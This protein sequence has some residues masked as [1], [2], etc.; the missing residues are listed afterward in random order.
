MNMLFFVERF[1]AIY[2]FWSSVVSGNLEDQKAIDKRDKGS[3]GD[4]TESN[5]SNLTS[6]CSD[7]AEARIRICDGTAGD[8]CQIKICGDL[9]PVSSTPTPV[10]SLN[11]KSKSQYNAS[12]TS[13]KSTADSGLKFL[14]IPTGDELKIKDLHLEEEYFIFQAFSGLMGYLF[15]EAFPMGLLKDALKSKFS[16]SLFFFEVLQLEVALLVWI[17]FWAALVLALPVGVAVSLCAPSKGRRFSNDLSEGSQAGKRSWTEKSF[18]CLLHVLLLIVLFPAG[19]ILAA[20]EQIARSISAV[21][22]QTIYDDL[23]VFVRNAHMQMAFVSTSS[24]DIAFETIRKDLEDIDLLLGEAYQQELSTETGIDHALIGLEEL[25]SAVARTTS[26]VSDLLIDCEVVSR[27]GEI[28]QDKLQEMSRQLIAIQQQC[29]AKD[30]PLCFTLQF[31]GFDLSLPVKN[32]TLD[33]KIQQLVRMN[34]ER[35]LNSSIEESRRAFLAIPDQVAIEMSPYVA[36]IKALLNKKR[37]DVYKS[38]QNLDTLAKTLA[39]DLNASQTKV[40]AFTEDVIRWDLWRWLIVLGVTAVVALTWGVLICGAPCGCGL[41]TKTIPLFHSGVGLS[42]C[43]CVILWALGTIS[44]LIGGHSK[45]FLCNPLYQS[46]Y[47]ETLSELLDANGVLYGEDGFFETISTKNGTVLVAE[48]LRSC[49]RDQTIY[50]P[51]HLKNHFDIEALLNYKNWEDLE[52][53]FENM[54]HAKTDADIISSELQV[55]LQV[56]STLTS[57]N[58]T[59]HRIRISTPTTKR[60]LGSFA[61]Q[62]NTV[63]RQI[64]DPVNARKFDNLAFSV[65]KLAQNELQKLNE[66]RG[67]I[68]YKV[69][70]LE[71]VLP[72]LNRRVN[73]S[74]SHLKT[75]RFFLDNRAW[76]IAQT[77][78]RRFLGKIENYLRDLYRHVAAAVAKEIGKCRPLWQIFHAG[79]F[80]ICKLIADPL[81]GIA[82]CCYFLI[83]LFIAITPI[84]IKLIDYYKE[85]QDEDI[86]TSILHRRSTQ[87]ERIW[88]GAIQESPENQPTDEERP[89]TSWTSPSVREKQEHRVPQPPKLPSVSSQ[90]HKP[91]VP[92]TSAVRRTRS[93]KQR[94]GGKLSTLT[95]RITGS[96]HLTEQMPAISRART[97]RRSTTPRSWM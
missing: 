3:L 44:L 63:A 30:R 17:A 85:D 46:P 20:N 69:T 56:L 21:P 90:V 76:Q 43:V 68:L 1:F 65:R 45:A 37:A 8:G 93:P 78:R 54:T 40:S 23:A 81:N 24:A 12:M 71:V 59:A 53:I 66:A 34:K 47:F 95:S 28:L 82:V 86:I 10:N 75:I 87:E 94:S 52:E 7:E 25:K 22:I 57:T 29:N 61:D 62:I 11:D 70:T 58:F 33:T 2:L 38:T 41:T 55:N 39:D 19:L 72:P 88:G 9:G 51:F 4:L 73:Q 15:P 48:V 92:H 60:D 36:D 50:K 16:F 26:V 49:Q 18:V 27:T 91:R 14:D 77:T 13:S 79:R 97:P 67:R 89:T 31:S 64:N 6:K 35:N 5:F 42:C 84:V 32:L 96:R 74:L 80:S 83:L